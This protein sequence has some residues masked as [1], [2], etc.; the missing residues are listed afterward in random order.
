MTEITFAERGIFGIHRKGSIVLNPI[1]R[2][3]EDPVNSCRCPESYKN[4][5]DP[6]W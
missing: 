5:L 3:F 6:Y 2:K 1:L 4:K